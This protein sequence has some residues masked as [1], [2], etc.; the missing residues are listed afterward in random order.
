[1]SNTY[2]K[3]IVSILVAN[4][5]NLGFSLLSSFLIPKILSTESYA[6]LK[7]FQLY[8]TYAGLL[9]LGY[10]DGLYLKWGGKSF[11]S[12]VNEQLEKDLSSLRI[13]QLFI[14]AISIC[15]GLC[16][17]NWIIVLFGFSILPANMMSCYKYLYQAV[18][19]FKIYSRIINATT[20]SYFI[21]NMFCLFILKTDNSTFYISVYILVDIVL[22]LI[23][24]IKIHKKLN[25][26]LISFK[27]SF[28]QTKNNISSGILLT[29]GNISSSF[30]TGM[31]RWFIKILMNDYAF[32][33]YAFAVSLENFLNVVIT[34]IS[35]TMYN[36]FC[37]ERDADSII[38]VRNV[39]QI[40]AAYIIACAFPA[41][42]I[43][44]LFLNKYLDSVN[45]MFYLFSAQLFYITIKCVYVNLYKADKRQKKYFLN[46]VVVLIFGALFN[47]ILYF[48]FKNKEVFAIATLVSAILWWF[49]N[50]F[51]YKHVKY[52]ARDCI[53]I[54]LVDILYL[55]TGNYL[56]T[57][58]GFCIY[59]F[60]VSLLSILF[61]RND[62]IYLFKTGKSI[63][64]SY[65]NKKHA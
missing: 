47:G 32:A 52:N 51:D 3:G 26:K 25:I 55:I 59:I 62:F 45:I 22:W 13:F 38:R 31:D 20:I 56:N 29:L 6:D 8:A 37:K 24:D 23:L 11:D 1:M 53:Y 5:I 41:K 63:L 43:I 64:N 46:V 60:A 33:Q 17:S 4:I 34:P 54:F 19:E 15:I 18:G 28:E 65:T 58:L 40:F 39:I 16:T 14:T 2:K 49:L 27:F 48:I 7:S 21:L 10:V 42:L 12:I 9:H 61:M 44:E 35:V 57:I 50:S 36:Y 30:L